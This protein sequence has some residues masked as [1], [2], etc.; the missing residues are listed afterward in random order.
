MPFLEAIDTDK[1]FS[2]IKKKKFKTFWHV[3]E[4]LLLKGQNMKFSESFKDMFKHMIYYNPNERIPLEKLLD[5]EW[6]QKAPAEKHLVH[7]DFL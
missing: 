4:K 2:L 1:V 5:H 6:V 3:Q 7:E